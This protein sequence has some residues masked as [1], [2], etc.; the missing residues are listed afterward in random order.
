MI[1]TIISVIYMGAQE[2]RIYAQADDIYFDTLYAINSDLVNADRD[3]YQAMIAATQCYDLRSLYKDL[4]EDEL[5]GY[6]DVKLAEYDENK[7]QVLARVDTAI[8]VAQENAD[9]YTG[10]VVEGDTK[11]FA[12]YVE[13]FEA[14]YAEWENTYDFANGAIKYKR[15]LNQ[16]KQIAT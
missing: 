14:G 4:P 10:T 12:D 13:A 2:Y 11:N 6:L 5:Q 16:V 9:I 3:F 7:D 1:V 8:V 15:L